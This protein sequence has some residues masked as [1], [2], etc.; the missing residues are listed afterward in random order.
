MQ[1]ELLKQQ[2]GASFVHVP[3][4]GDTPAIQDTL[5]EQV[6]FMFAPVAAAMPHVRSGRLR[7]LASVASLWA[8]SSA[9]PLPGAS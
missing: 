4:K 2:T 1:A 8:V 9:C 3:Y 6:Q 5:S 7:A